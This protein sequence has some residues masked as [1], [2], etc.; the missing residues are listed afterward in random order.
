[1]LVGGLG[2]GGRGYYALDLTD[3]SSSS[4]DLPSTANKLAERV[5]WEYPNAYTS[6]SEIA[7]L[8][9]SYS[10]PIIAQSNDTAN[11]M[12]LSA[13]VLPPN[14]FVIHQSPFFNP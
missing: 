12:W 4:S 6:N 9:Y 14:V 11:G 13:T 3:L 1:M 5:L 7:D 2:K 10:V 8:G